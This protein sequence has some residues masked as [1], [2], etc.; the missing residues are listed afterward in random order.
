MPYAQDLSSF[1]DRVKLNRVFV[2][3]EATGAN[4]FARF[5]PVDFDFHLVYVGVE[6]AF[7]VTVGVTY[8]VARNLTFTANNTYSAHCITHLLGAVFCSLF[9]LA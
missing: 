9:L 7:R 1:H 6:R 3:S 4:V 2:S 8:V 5:F